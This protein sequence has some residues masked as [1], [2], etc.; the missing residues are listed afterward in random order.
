MDENN[1]GFL[2][3]HAYTVLKMNDNNVWLEESNNPGNAIVISVDKFM[4]IFDVDICAI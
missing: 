3:N 2:S 4:D 1:S